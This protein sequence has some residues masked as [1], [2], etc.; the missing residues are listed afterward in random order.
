MTSTTL[1]S[2]VAANDLS[3]RVASVAGATPGGFVKIDNEYMKVVSVNSPIVNVRER[4][5]EGGTAA[6]HDVNASVV[7]GI[8]SELPPLA[9]GELIPPP[10]EDRDQ[11][12]VGQDMTIPWNVLRRDATVVIAKGSVAAITLEA[13]SAAV[14]GTRLTITSQS[15][16]AHVV[17]ATGLIDNGVTGGAKNTLTFAAF[18]GATV[19][20]QANRGKWTVVGTSAVTVG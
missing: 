14:D 8:G 19:T 3:I 17:T 13:P 5:G 1:T 12:T 18:A 6:D 7:F 20:L 15:A 9:P 10:T 2:G 4:G 11:I 16:F